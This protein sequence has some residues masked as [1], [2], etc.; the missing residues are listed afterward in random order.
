MK[1]TPV[2]KNISNYESLSPENRMNYLNEQMFF[3]EPILYDIFCMHKLYCNDAI[4]TAFRSGQ[5]K[6]EY[7]S[8]IIQSIPLVEALDLYRTELIRILLL[9]PYMRKPEPFDEKTAYSASEITIRQQPHLLEKLGLKKR[10]SFEYYYKNLLPKSDAENSTP[11][12]KND[13]RQQSPQQNPDTQDN[14]ENNSENSPTALWQENDLSSEIVKTKIEEW[15]SFNKYWGTTAC[16]FK[17]QALANLE[18]KI[19]YKKILRS[20]RSSIISDKKMLTRF[21]PSRRFDFL[22]MG[23]KYD[24]TTKLLVAVDVSGSITDES[25]ENFLGVIEKIFKYGIKEVDLVFFDVCIKAPK[26]TLTKRNKNYDFTGRGGTSF[27]C[28]FDYIEENPGYDGCI[29][30]TDGD[31]DEPQFSKKTGTR[32]AW[33]CESEST[34]RTHKYWMQKT[35]KAGYIKKSF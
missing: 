2:G 33:I 15:R 25:V 23:T 26:V 13:G 20:F 21:K 29:I 34:Y 30:F 28:V 35:G 31:A 4:S 8:K 9:H 1:H 10:E 11:Q 24:F 3:Y 6:V 22:Y 32:I 14:Q 5:M 18:A 7:N 17:S 16:Y 27:Q 12:N 19:D